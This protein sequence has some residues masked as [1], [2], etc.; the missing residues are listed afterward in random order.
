MHGTAIVGLIA[1]ATAAGCAPVGNLGMVG[2]ASSESPTEVWCRMHSFDLGA[3]SRCVAAARR[4][5]A[6]SAPVDK[7]RYGADASQPRPGEVYAP[8][9]S[10]QPRPGEVYNPS[11]YCLWN[12]SGLPA[13]QQ[14]ICSNLDQKAAAAAK[15]VHGNASPAL[16][17][18][19][20][21]MIELTRITKLAEVAGICQL[22]SERWFEV[23]RTNYLMFRT[24][25]ATRLKL[26][27]AEIAAANVKIQSIGGPQIQ[28]VGP[29]N[30]CEK[31]L[32]SPVMD[33]LDAFERK[34]TG[35]YH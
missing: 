7:Y 2:T 15:R 28:L 1:L 12:R 31:M 24:N 27:N 19:E 20:A 25:E 9:Q 4:G 23:F 16:L 18:Y 3:A 5:L 30:T 6:E 32:N 14:K 13:A 21:K 8:E 33:Q 22:R 26:S 11:T 34:L 17:E 29:G 35:N 10:W